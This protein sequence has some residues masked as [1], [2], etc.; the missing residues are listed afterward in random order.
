MKMHIHDSLLV[1]DEMSMIE[2]DETSVEEIKLLV[3]SV[4]DLS[5]NRNE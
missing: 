5:E 2:V 3:S 4:E 1:D